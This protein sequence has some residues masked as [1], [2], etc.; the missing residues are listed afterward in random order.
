M[1]RQRGDSSDEE[2][3]ESDFVIEDNEGPLGVPDYASLMPLEFTQ[4]AHKP[5]KE[6][7]RDVVE[8]M[9]QN[10][11]NPGFTWNDPVYNQAFQK[12]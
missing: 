2:A 7:F 4:A 12:L 6:H 10:K 9:I 5:L 1:K 3:G 8:W 11:L